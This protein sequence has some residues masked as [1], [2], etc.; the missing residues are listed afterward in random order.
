MG[1]TI[2]TNL[3]SLV[4]QQ[5]LQV[6]SNQLKVNVQRLSS[7]FRVNSA[8]DDAAG[9]AR[10]DQLKAQSVAVQAAIRNSNDGISALEIMDKSAEKITDL[11]VRMNDLAA[12]SA[13]GTLDATTR[14]YYSGE[15]DALLEEINRIATVTE[16]GNAPLLDGSTATLDL[17]IGFRGTVDDRLTIATADFFSEGQIQASNYIAL[18]PA[19]T[20]IAGGAPGDIFEFTYDGATYTL[21]MSVPTTLDQLVT[22]I[23]AAVGATVAST[24]ESAPGS[25]NWRL[26]LTSGINGSA[27]DFTGITNDTLMAGLGT[28]NGQASSDAFTGI[29]FGAIS[30]QGGAQ[31]ALG[32]LETALA[33]VNTARASFGANTNRLSTTISNLQVT[34]TNFQAAESRIRD[35][36]FAMETA[37][38]TRNQILVQSGVAVLAQANTLPES[39]LSLL[40]A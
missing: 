28:A 37:S 4:A 33:T 16:F 35:A 10:A 17:Q 14:G 31:T 3:S 30:T 32:T 34:F 2:N 21:D 18:T 40:S 27:G 36:D 25:G 19:V 13:Q 6:S 24:Q 1:L 8:A 26:V 20:D 11:L 7:G 29:T 5:N 38:F 15:F 22:D 9:L 12:S 23:N 39:A